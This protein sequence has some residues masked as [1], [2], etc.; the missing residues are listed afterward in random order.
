MQRRPSHPDSWAERPWLL[1]LLI[2]ACTACAA[3]S[4]AWGALPPGETFRATLRNDFGSS[5]GCLYFSDGGHAHFPERGRWGE[6]AH[7][8]RRL[9]D[10][11]D[12]ALW[13]FT[14]LGGDRYMITNGSSGSEECLGYEHGVSEGHPSRRTWG[15]GPYCGHPGGKEGLLHDRDAVW[16][17]T[18]LEGDRYVITSGS[19]G[20]EECLGFG[21]D[22]LSRYPGPLTWGNGGAFCG[23][24][25]GGSGLLANRQAVFQIEQAPVAFHP[26]QAW[27]DGY[28]IFQNNR[29]GHQRLHVGHNGDGRLYTDWGSDDA[30]RWK[31]IPTGDGSTYFLENTLHPQRLHVGHNGNGQLYAQ[32]G[33][34]DA[35]RWSFERLEGRFLLRNKRHS[36]QRLHVGH[37]GNG[38]LYAQWGDDSAYRWKVQVL[39][40]TNS[41]ADD[42]FRFSAYYLTRRI[43]LQNRYYDNQALHVGHDG[44]GQ[45][46]AESGF[47][48]AYLWKFEPGPQQ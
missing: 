27:L 39:A 20:S 46:Y 24:L 36:D 12:P 18:Q 5:G 13:T 41:A 44:N 30:Y 45:L 6:G 47:D 23:F 16:K 19:S 33:S 29:H 7:C 25:G 28:L 32:W 26:P 38:Q 14:P 34:D 2:T 3:G 17:I 8:G 4:T 10:P 9:T 31:I 37:D 40:D 22:A 21:A 43:R 42:E 48:N 1:T 35:Y 15:E 11:H